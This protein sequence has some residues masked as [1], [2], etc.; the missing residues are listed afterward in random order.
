MPQRKRKRG[1]RARE[2]LWA[3]QWNKWKIYRLGLVRRGG[4]NDLTLSAAGM[5]Q[6]ISLFVGQISAEMLRNLV[7]EFSLLKLQERIQENFLTG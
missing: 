5:W 4:F 3:D 1:R 6:K 2:R 7:L